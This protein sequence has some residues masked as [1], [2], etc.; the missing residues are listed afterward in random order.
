MP[1]FIAGD[2]D[3]KNVSFMKPQVASCSQDVDITMGVESTLDALELANATS[4]SR[5]NFNV[6][7]RGRVDVAMTIHVLDGTSVRITGISEAVADGRGTVPIFLVSNGYLYLN[8]IGIANGNGSEGGAILAVSRSELVIEGVTF[9]S[10][11][12]QSMGGAISARS[13]NATLVSTTFEGNSADVGGA[14]GVLNSILIAKGYTNFH[15][16]SAGY[17]GAVFASRNSIV[18]GSRNTTYINNTATE[19]GGAIFIAGTSY[20]GWSMQSIL[21]STAQHSSM[22][23]NSGENIYT[24]ASSSFTHYPDFSS[25]AVFSAE[26]YGSETEWIDI[27]ESGDT[28]FMHNRAEGLGGAIYAESSKICC[29][30][31]TSLIG[32]SAQYGGALYLENGAIIEIHGVTAFSSNNAVFDGGAIGAEALAYTDAEL[33]ANGSL[34]FTNNTCGGNGGAIHLSS[35]YFVVNGSVSFS[36]NSALSFGGALYASQKEEGPILNGV[37]FSNNVAEA[38]GAVFFSAVGTYKSSDDDEDP[39][40]FSS[41]F[42]RCRFEGNSA[43]TMG[44]A[45]YTTA[46]K[47]LVWKTSFINNSANVGGA[48]Q[49][50]G[51]ANLRNSSFVDNTSGEG[52]GPAIFNGG[53]ISEMVG[54]YFSDN[55]YYCS[56]DAFMGLNEV[57]YVCS[58]YTLLSIHVRWQCLNLVLGMLTD[59]LM[60]QRSLAEN[61]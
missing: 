43:S 33:I 29:S 21:R 7:W 30:G 32:N 12:A 55:G 14:V 31:S 4:C 27:N 41:R 36:G 58:V 25:C 35:I 9:T 42:I 23:S 10:N 16:N 51:T 24:S 28:V 1:L 8:N 56:P 57:R 15:D 45:I 48:L 61:E 44:G 50:S 59:C 60:R 22:Y 47:D 54:V 6:E 11:T 13:S 5:R 40:S 53:V 38:G 39:H 2:I 19:N 49:I 34:T 18:I 52:G 26:V 20:L 46:G 3:C 37:N 17:G